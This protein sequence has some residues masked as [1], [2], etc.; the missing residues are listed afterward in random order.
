MG[1][2]VGA[3]SMCS[4]RY[5]A[6][7]LVYVYGLEVQTIHRYKYKGNYRLEIRRC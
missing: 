3:G 4:N 6:Y 2:Q 5:G 1:D 7:D